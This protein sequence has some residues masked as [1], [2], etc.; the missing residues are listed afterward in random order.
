[1]NP[2]EF[3]NEKNAKSNSIYC[4]YQKNIL[5][6]IRITQSR[7]SI[8]PNQLK[9]NLYAE[10]IKVTDKRTKNCILFSSLIDGEELDRAEEVHPNTPST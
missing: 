4:S 9:F 5:K 8:I 2:R 7:K 3:Q 6:V 10:L 1:M